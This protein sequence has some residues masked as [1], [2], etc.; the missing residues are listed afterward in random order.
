MGTKRGL[1]LSQYE[2]LNLLLEAVRLVIDI[3]ERLL[4]YKKKKGK[5][6]KK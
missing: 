5:R 3:I 1:L 4:Y 2:F 6:V